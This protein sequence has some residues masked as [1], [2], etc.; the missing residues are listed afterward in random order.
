VTQRLPRVLWLHEHRYVLAAT[1]PFGLVEVERLR[2][3]FLQLMTSVDRLT[4]F[5][6]FDQAEQLRLAFKHW[7]QYY[8][9][10][11]FHHLIEQA[12]YEQIMDH[13][14]ERKAIPRTQTDEWKPHWEKKLRQGCW[15]LVHEAEMRMENWQHL[16]LGRKYSGEAYTPDEL[17]QRVFSTFLKDK[18]KWAARARREA[19]KAWEALREYFHWLEFTPATIKV[20]SRETATIEGFKCLLVGY[21]DIDPTLSWQQEAM[22]LLREGLRRYRRN[23]IATMPWLLRHQLPLEIRFETVLEKGGSYH[24][25]CPPH[26]TFYTSTMGDPDRAAWVLAHEMGHHIY[27]TYLSTPQST[28]WVQFIRGDYDPLDLEKLHKLW[29]TIGEGRYY[30]DL[31]DHLREHDPVM[32][33]QVQ[34]LTHGYGR[35]E[36]FFSYEELEALLAKGVK[37]APVPRHPITAYATKNPEEAF[38]EVVGLLVGHGPR[39]VLPEV[40]RW[41]TT[42]VPELVTNAMVRMAK[43][44]P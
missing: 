29:A 34:G 4:A 14:G 24:R 27:E 31:E 8:E 30:S 10:T 5:E 1:V 32:L 19:R 12:L 11:I 38:C 28:A 40:R 22:G 25:C 36:L 2:K 39:A 6:Q 18:S 15:G 44:R 23:A 3:D 26:I 7:R 16:D 9:E 13:L 41:F 17:K 42:V 37:Q 21:D 35:G 33:L 20:P 43:L